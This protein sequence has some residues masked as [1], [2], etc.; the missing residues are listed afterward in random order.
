MKRFLD[1]REAVPEREETNSRNGQEEAA[2]VV[3]SFAHLLV[4]F[5]KTL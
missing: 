5:E 1:R 4:A 3:A 2:C